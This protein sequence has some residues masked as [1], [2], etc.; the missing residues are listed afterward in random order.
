MSAPILA[1]TS[2]QDLPRVRGIARLLLKNPLRALTSNLQLPAFRFHF[3]WR[4][5]IVCQDPAMIKDVLVND[6]RSYKKSRAFRVLSI[7]LGN[8]LLTSEGEFWRQQRRL[9]QP[10]FHKKRIEAMVDTFAACTETTLASI[11]QQPEGKPVDFTREFARLT[12]DIICRTMFGVDM[13]AETDSVWQNVNKVNAIGISRVRNPLTP[14]VWVPTPGNI[15]TQKSLK[16]L[17]DIVNPMIADR[18][19]GKTQRDDLLQM[20]VDVRDED[21]GEGM[22]PQQIRDEVMTIFIA[23]HETTVNALSWAIWLLDQ[24]PAERTRLITELDTVLAGRTPTLEDLAK[25]PHLNRVILESMRL[26]P[27]A[28]IIGRE[29]ITPTTAGGK[30][31][32]VGETMLINVYGLHRHPDYWD[33]PNA[34]RPDRF[35]EG[36]AKGESRFTYFPFGGGPR[37]CIGNNFALIEMQIILAML[38]SRYTLDCPD[39]SAPETDPLFTLKPKVGIMATAQE[40]SPETSLS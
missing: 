8:G 14:P 19:S 2:T 4:R 20:L 24:N 13:R 1:P 10:A 29:C 16:V 6:V 40:R 30:K 37:Q 3:L 28:Y 5:I 18:L 25:M 39:K 31:V 33:E 21:T 9:S 15:S 35:T 27:P 12:I 32:K 23:G 38:Y 7:L 11:K 22:N 36:M 17:D 34:F 26:Y